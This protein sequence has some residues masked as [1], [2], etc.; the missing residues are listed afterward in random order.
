[1]AD[2]VACQEFVGALAG[3]LS[4]KQEPKPQHPETKAATS[5]KG[6]LKSYVLGYFGTWDW[7][8]LLGALLIL[9][10]ALTNPRL[11]RGIEVTQRQPGQGLHRRARQRPPQL[12]DR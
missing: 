10:N 2:G 1:M 11:R 3:P 4:S 8:W 12:P 7:R 6:R 5:Q 9:A